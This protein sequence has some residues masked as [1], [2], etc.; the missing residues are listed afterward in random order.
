MIILIYRKM[1]WRRL[2][3]AFGFSGAETHTII[4]YALRKH[5]D[6]EYALRVMAKL[7]L[8]HWDKRGWAKLGVHN[9][10]PFMRDLGFDKYGRPRGTGEEWFEAT[11]AY[12]IA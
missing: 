5:L 9:R 8:H 10:T 12:M 4:N 3:F 6:P 1:R 7:R 11:L 2:G